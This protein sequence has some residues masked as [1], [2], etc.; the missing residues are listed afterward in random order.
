V[1]GAEQDQIRRRRECLRCGGRFTTF[2]RAEFSLPRVVKRTGE[3]VAFD[4]E[5]RWLR[6][7]RGAVTLALNLGPAP[8]AVP[9]PLGRA[10]AVLLSSDAALEVGSDTVRL[11]PD[12]VALLGP[13]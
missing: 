13:P 6:L 3:R 7:E 1:A 4:E 8:Q 10:R 11:C 5:A 2:E 9:L 12:G